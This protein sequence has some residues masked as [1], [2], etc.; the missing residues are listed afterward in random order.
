MKG[1]IKFRAKNTRTGAWEFFTLKQVRE[2]HDL[3]DWETVG[4]SFGLED[5]QGNTLYDG[6]IL[7]HHNGRLSDPLEFPKDYLWLKSRIENASATATTI[8]NC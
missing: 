8:R 6:D 1:K 5:K 4:Q 2:F 7:K 3:I